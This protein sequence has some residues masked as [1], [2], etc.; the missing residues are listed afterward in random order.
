[1]QQDAC[2]TKCSQ[3]HE[4]NQVKKKGK[5]V[6]SLLEKDVHRHTGTAVTKAVVN[7]KVAA[8]S[9]TARP[10]DKDS[11]VDS[12]PMQINFINVQS[13]HCPIRL[14]AGHQAEKNGTHSLH[15]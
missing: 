5:P 9:Q 15:N 6:T 12:V 4:L 11:L 8:N 7:D 1:L 13:L 14:E 10:Y 2:D 3:T